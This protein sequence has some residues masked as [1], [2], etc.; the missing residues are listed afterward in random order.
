MIKMVTFWVFPFLICLWAGILISTLLALVLKKLPYDLKKKRLLYCSI[1]TFLFFPVLTPAGTIAGIPLP[2]ILTLALSINDLP[3]VFELYIATWG[4]T[5][6]SVI[7]TA[8]TFWL[9][10][11]IFFFKNPYTKANSG[12]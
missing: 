1:G 3:K 4:F 9:A 6:L 12:E 10:S 11:N 2:N 8:L 7:I 5:I